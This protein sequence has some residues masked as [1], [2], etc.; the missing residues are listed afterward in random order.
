MA[1]SNFPTAPL[2]NTLLPESLKEEQ[3]L[4]DP[5]QLKFIMAKE[6]AMQ[7][8]FHNIA[9]SMG[10]RDTDVKKG[11]NPLPVLWKKTV[12]EWENI[13]PSQ[14]HPHPQLYYRLY[15]GDHKNLLD[16]P[17]G[18][19]ID[20]P[21]NKKGD[22]ILFTP[23]TI[24]SQ[25]CTDFRQYVKDQGYLP[26]GLC[27]LVFRQKQNWTYSIVITRDKNGPAQCDWD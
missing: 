20:I 14:R 10:A 7:I 13:H 8:L 18:T 2:N 4:P 26:E 19:E 24:L 15:T 22:P 25:N 9:M 12:C 17:V 21:L 23:S 11:E 5:N 3:P 6:R 27:L 16:G 1:S